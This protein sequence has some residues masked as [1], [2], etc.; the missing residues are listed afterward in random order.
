LAAL[1]DVLLAGAG[2]LDH[3]VD[4]A[5]ALLEEP[6]AEP[7][8]GVVDDLRFLVGEKALVTAMGRYK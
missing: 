5:V 1:D 6:G 8:G 7:D 2:G 3:L 4:R